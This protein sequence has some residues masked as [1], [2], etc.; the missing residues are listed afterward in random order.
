M[1]RIF[2]SV[3]A[4]ATIS[5]LGASSLNE[6][7][8]SYHDEDGREKLWKQ[9]SDAESKSLP[10]T[11]I[12]HAQAIYDS[13]MQDKDYPEAVRAL[14]KKLTLDASINQP[15]APYLIKKLT[16]EVD[17]YPD[18]I[19]PVMKVILANWFFTYYQ[20]NRWRFAQRSQTAQVPSDDFETWDL[21]RLLNHIDS[22]F[23]D[24]LQEKEQLKQIGIGEYDELIRKGNVSDDYR[25]TLFDFIAF[26]A[27]DFYSLD[28][29]I[30]RQQGA[31]DV[32]ADGPVFSSKDEFLAW[33]PK[34][35][36]DDSFLLQAVKLYQD[37]LN[38]HSVDKDSTARLDADLHR[39]KFANMVAVGSEKQARYKAA[40]R[41][42]VDANIEHPIASVALSLLAGV[43]QAE[44]DFATAHKLASQGKERHPDSRGARLC[45]NIIK[46][47]ETRE[48]NVSTERVW[49]SA[50]PS[51]DVSYRNID[52]V[53][54]RV[55]KFDYLNWKWGDRRQ[56]VNIGQ[57][58]LQQL[59]DGEKVTQWSQE[60]KPTDDYKTRIETT[61]VNVELDSGCYLLFASHRED[62]Q[63]KDNHVSVTEI[64][65]SE[66]AIV[67]RN[68]HSKS[69]FSGQLTNANTGRPIAGAKITASKWIRDGRNSRSVDLNPVVSDRDGIFS[70]ELDE[71]RN[72]SIPVRVLVAHED[73]QL[74]LINSS[75]RYRSTHGGKKREQ[76]IF[77]TDRSLYRP[78]QTIH[79]KGI[80]IVANQ[81]SS[82]YST[83]QNQS[84]EILFQDTNG[85]EIERRKLRTNQFGSFSGSFSAPQGVA[86]GHMNLQVVSG[87]RGSAGIRVEEYK[88]PKF[89]VEV[90]KP[91]QEFRLNEE[92]R[93]SGNA[94][95]YTGAPIDGAKVVWRVVREVRYPD[96]WMWRCWYCMPPTGES[97]EI[98]NGTTETDVD[99]AF[100]IN[101][102]A[103]P[104]LSVERESEPIFTYTVYADVTDTTG[105][106]RSSSQY[107]RIGYNSLKASIAADRW[108]TTQQPV[109]LRLATTTLD[110]KGQTAKGRLVI[111]ALKPPEKVQR[112]ELNTNRYSYWN[113]PDDKPE[114]DLS[115]IDSW[116]SGAI[117]K[118]FPIETGGDGK[119]EQLVELGAGAY[120]CVF[121]TSDSSGQKVKSE[122]PFLVVDT[123]SE[124]FATKIPHFFDAKTWSVEPGE[125][126]VALWGTGYETGQAFVEV[127]HR[128]KIIHSYWTEPNATQARITQEVSEDMRGG[129]VVHLTYVRENR[130]YV[131]SRTV[132]VPWSNKKLQI[133]W[134]HF[135]SKLQP[136]GKETWTAVISGPDAERAAAEMVA[137][138][139]DASLDAFAP[140]HWSSS[141]N[142]FYRDFTHR[143]RQ[144]QNYLNNFR[145]LYYGWRNDWQDG[146]IVYRHFEHFVAPQV[147]YGRTSRGRGI[148][149]KS[150]TFAES[151]DS[152]SDSAVDSLGL[153]A[154]QAAPGRMDQSRFQNELME[155][156]IANTRGDQE[157]RTGPDLDNVAARKNLNE[158]AFFFP[159]LQVDENGTVRIEFEIPEALTK[160]RFFGFAHDNDLKS[161]LMTD[162]IVTSKDLM[163]QPN[164]P[165]FLREGDVLE[166]SVKVINQSATRQSGSVRLTF[167]DA[168][169]EENMDDELAIANIDQSFDIPAGQSKSLFWTLTM[170]DY[171]GVLTYKA[172]GATDRLSDGEEGFL[173]VLTKRIL[174]TES[175]PLPIRG[176]QTRQFNFER[177]KLAD[178]SDS[179]Q[180]QTL[181]LQMTS[182]PA[183]YAVMALPYLMEYPHQ[184]S[185][186]IFNRY[187]ANSIGKYIVS[188]DPRI[189]KIF[190]QW[191]GTDALDSPL[192]KNDDIRNVLIAES[193]WLRDAKKESQARRDVAILF[194]ENRLNQELSQAMKQLAERQYSD[195]AWPWFPGGRANDYIT[196]Y[197]TTGLGRLRHLGINSDVA[198]AI[199]ALDRLDHWINKTYL[200]IKRRDR[201]ESNHLSPTI[202]MYLY[203]RSFFLKD[204]SIDEKYKVASDYFVKQAQ[205]HWAKLDNRQSQAHAA[206]ALTRFGQRN[207][208]REIMASLT[209]RATM[210]DELGMLWKE[211]P[212]WWWYRAPIETQAM[213]IEA[214]DEVMGDA[215]KVEECK[216]WLLKQKQTQ[217]WKTTKATADACYALLRRGSNL[218][219]SS[220]LVDVSLGG[221]QIKPENF[222]AG[223]GFFEKRFV[224]GEIVA[225]M[226]DVTVAKRDDGIAWG[227]LHWQYLE[228]AAKV[229]PYEGTPL[230][231]KKGLFIKKNTETGPK[232][233]PVK[234]AV[235]VGD[236]LVTRVEL[237][238]DRDMEYVHLK[239]YRGSGTEPVNVLSQYKSQDG[240]WYY[241][242]TKDTASH[243]FIDYLPRGTYVFEYS[244]RVQHKGQYQTG[245]AELQCMYAPEFNSHSGSVEIVVQ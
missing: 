48:I 68:D 238:V 41:R 91:E 5:I 72:R 150:A 177:L 19:K 242:S 18:A 160:W 9:V 228:D 164:P 55:V 143:N 71:R 7:T 183:W 45:H 120:R 162:E 22:L 130:C 61:K 123:G 24:S 12:K 182:N 221:L 84:V 180:S 30:V 52:K 17:D 94:T 204:K 156:E 218:L 184:C 112:V 202:C 105:E 136:G 20:Q 98:A 154:P 149:R 69:Q 124:R 145:Q 125:T 132:D 169:T 26:Q 66:L 50:G 225:E 86:T 227:S 223:T 173:P 170:P 31:F 114:P 212:S 75:Y 23:R 188:S 178:Q 53:Y 194:E 96:W 197:I 16:A 155:G 46:Q 8:A 216:I 21:A 15:A 133:K 165:R 104:D 11:G 111:Y 127:E 119:A 6:E 106:T 117:V 29:Q 85:Q 203:G 36:D 122:K 220:R 129:F 76:T 25:P 51:I 208:A 33:D 219:A 27:L 234:G 144:F 1:I 90:E 109:E 62:F 213:M 185:E 230:T 161:A 32:L 142:V 4:V 67:V 131:V 54:F 113:R 63:E 107:L 97:Q 147:Y 186:Q 83:I 152:L 200:E 103:I 233:E 95:A 74:G 110:G 211:A 206:V 229:E 38:F 139:Y 239:D 217:G 171:V 192:E 153:A 175:L 57:K 118:E 128:G 138:M 82:D 224:R 37:L 201:L 100:K 193:P 172:V 245:I 207:S 222:E 116:P 168:R 42:F 196:L 28:E 65:V 232:I 13:A 167:T 87:P 60:L 215:E 158:T 187:Y 135:V 181:T 189:K 79:F 190:D 73:Q 78:G 137:T 10:R 64:W 58:Q 56:P 210:D 140:H 205:E 49:N 108:L 93:V 3:V 163:V 237:R 214:Y 209:E 235:Q 166:F 121:E 88:R 77:F 14:M 148:L 226:G 92:I 44:Q 89:I 102:K 174:V 231:L 141:F 70:I 146:A 59:L 40:L 198:P 99:G 179:L 236:E 191:R 240:L 243:F 195:G 80:C 199:K 134:E 241:E 244:V 39:L 126:F 35:N 159:H 47:I 115:R 81:K 43:F 151:A 101:F 2:I 34:T 176:N 157:A